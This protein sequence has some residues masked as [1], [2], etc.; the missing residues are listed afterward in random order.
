MNSA[1]GSIPITQDGPTTQARLATIV[2]GFD[3]FETE[4]RRGTRYY[5]S[6]IDIYIAYKNR[7]SIITSVDNVEKKMNL[8][9]LN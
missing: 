9:S 2:Q 5:S 4:M 6:Y 3:N 8:E 1:S 7:V